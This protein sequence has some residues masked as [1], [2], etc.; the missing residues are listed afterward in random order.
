MRMGMI[1]WLLVLMPC[2]EVRASEVSS[3]KIV[4]A[5][6]Y[7]ARTVKDPVRTVLLPR[8]LSRYASLK[9]QPSFR[10]QREFVLVFTI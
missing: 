10:R 6:I 1:L 7:T 5:G 9:P 8:G 4:E 3:I 2:S